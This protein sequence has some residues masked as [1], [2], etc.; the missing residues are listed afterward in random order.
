MSMIQSGKPTPNSDSPTATRAGDIST[1]T[2]VTYPTPFPRGAEVILHTTVQTFN[3]ADTPGAR[4]H[5]ADNSGFHIRLNE[6]HG[7]GNVG[8]G[9][10]RHTNETIGWTA[11]TVRP[12][13]PPLTGGPSRDSGPNVRR[14]RPLPGGEP[15]SRIGA[16][17]VRRLSRSSPTG[18]TP[19]AS[20]GSR[21]GNR[22]GS[23]RTPVR[24]TGHDRKGVPP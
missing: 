19:P 2:R 9:D 15:F 14:A 23:G 22:A 10:G 8:T 11:R 6:I 4:L 12:H 24:Q 17:L 21:Q 5:N 3:G 1:F 13:R 18:T 16:S 20:P 7:Q